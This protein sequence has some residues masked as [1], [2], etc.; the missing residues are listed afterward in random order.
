MQSELVL[1]IFRILYDLLPKTT[2]LSF[3]FQESGLYSQT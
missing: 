1:L 3:R 2:I